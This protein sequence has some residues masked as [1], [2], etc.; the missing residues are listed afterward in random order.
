[1]IDLKNFEKR[2][3]VLTELSN[4]KDNLNELLT[5]LTSE[6]KKAKQIHQKELE[7]MNT[8]L[9]R[10]KMKSTESEWIKVSK[11]KPKNKTIMEEKS[12]VSKFDSKFDSNNR[13]DRNDIRNDIRTDNNNINNNMANFAA[14]NVSGVTNQINNQIDKNNH[15]DSNYEPK[16]QIEVH[17]TNALFLVA[18]RVVTFDQVKQDGELYYV[19]SN[20]HFAIKISGMLFHGNVGIIYTEEKNPTKIKKCKFAEQ[21]IK[22][23]KCDYYHD[24]LKFASSTDRRNFIA[25][26]FLYAPPNS[27]FKNGNK[28]RRFGSL[29]NLETDMA[30][31]HEEEISRFY[32][33]SFHDILCSMLLKKYSKE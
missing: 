2:Q 24:P 9:G 8:F 17:L 1:M 26:S 13:V 23:N 6:I 14:N 33:Q 30:S 32:D 25:S 18:N 5:D 11:S 12:L 27:P 16:K 19:E 31:M 22:G 15:V 28:S 3:S 4:I 10:L 20:N 29:P 21:C 7:N